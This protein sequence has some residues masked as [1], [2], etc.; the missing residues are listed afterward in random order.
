[1]STVLV[2]IFEHKWSI[3][4]VIYFSFSFSWLE[5]LQCICMASSYEYLHGNS[6]LNIVSFSRPK[7]SFC[8]NICS[9][10]AAFLDAGFWFL[11]FIFWFASMLSKNN[12]FDSVPKEIA[13]LTMLE[14][15]DLRSNKLNGPLPI[16]IGDMLSL[17][18][19]W[20]SCCDFILFIFLIF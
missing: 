7:N 1:M 18:C 15:L 8:I 4:H 3:L 19:L 10:F 5:V 17:K 16:E 20:V 12:F 9:W 2:K 11:F 13:K 14:V 6:F